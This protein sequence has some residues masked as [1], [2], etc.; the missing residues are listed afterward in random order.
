MAASNAETNNV[1]KVVIQSQ[2]HAVTRWLGHAAQSLFGKNGPLH[3]TVGAHGATVHGV[4]ASLRA[5]PPGEALG[6]IAIAAVVLYMV[7]AMATRALS[8]LVR[9]AIIAGVVGAAYLVLK[10]P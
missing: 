6:I 9:L 8:G 5:M 2:W 3:R 4:L 7:L 1:A 10:R